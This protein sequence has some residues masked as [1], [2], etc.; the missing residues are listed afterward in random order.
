MSECQDIFLVGFSGSGKTVSGRKLADALNAAFYDT[1]SLIA[2]RARMNIAGIF[3]RMGESGFREL[4]E[5]IILEL[6][7]DGSG[8]RRVIALGGGALHGR[9][10]RSAIKGNGITIYLSC[11]RKVLYR[12]LRDLTDRPV[13]MSNQRKTKAPAR[14][15]RNKINR[16]LNMRIDNYREAHIR[17]ATTNRTPDEVV[18]EIRRKL[19]MTRG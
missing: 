15:L 1:D 18:Q 6:V 11:S 17:V 5:E 12:R 7:A 9:K 19:G 4:E 16:L 13:L 3:E 8:E 10:V 14:Q 2:K